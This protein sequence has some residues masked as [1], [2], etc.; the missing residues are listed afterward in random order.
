MTD[1]RHQCRWCAELCYGDVLYCS[2]KEQTMSESSVK[3]V[4]KCKE[5]RFC[6]MDVFT[7]E[8]YKPR[9]HHDKQVK[10][11]MGFL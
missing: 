7:H 8:H 3:R 1:T 9:E 5:F 6:D 2:A 10:G 11:Q 4:N